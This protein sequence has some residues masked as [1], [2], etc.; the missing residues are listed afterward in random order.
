VA[1]E[2]DVPLSTFAIRH[3][4]PFAKLPSVILK[5]PL[6]EIQPKQGS[7]QK[8]PLDMPVSKNNP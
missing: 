3:I 8:S 6:K 1:F 2:G 4:L 5:H 7:N